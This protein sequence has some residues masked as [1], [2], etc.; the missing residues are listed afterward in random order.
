MAFKFTNSH[1]QVFLYCEWVTTGVQ[2]TITIFAIRSNEMGL[3]EI[4]IEINID[5]HKK[6]C[7][8]VE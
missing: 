5:V 1:A 3:L 2:L 7:L 4:L 6:F 8:R